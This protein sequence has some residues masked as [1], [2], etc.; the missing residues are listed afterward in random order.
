MVVACL[1]C[2]K[3]FSHRNEESKHGFCSVACLAAAGE[4]SGQIAHD[5]QEAEDA[6]RQYIATDPRDLPKVAP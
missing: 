1:W 4:E 2:R 5:A 6:Y 3:P